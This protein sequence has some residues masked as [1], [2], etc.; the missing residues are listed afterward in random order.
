MD[1]TAN[2]HMTSSGYNLNDLVNVSNLNLRVNH[3]NGSTAKIYKIG[4][5]NLSNEVTLFEVFVV[6]E[7]NVNLLSIQKLCKDSKCKVLFDE[8]KCMVSD[9]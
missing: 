5:L 7:F 1:S 3:P 8:Y 4:N 2:Q 6:T 9:S